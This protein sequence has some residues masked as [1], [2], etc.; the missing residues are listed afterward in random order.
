[1]LVEGPNFI[2]LYK[3]YGVHRPGTTASITTTVLAM[4]WSERVSA[5]RFMVTV[6]PFHGFEGLWRV[7]EGE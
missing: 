1:M 2:F 4:E 3:V 7:D 6:L 5:C